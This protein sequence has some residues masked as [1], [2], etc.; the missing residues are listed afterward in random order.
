MG[1]TVTLWYPILRG[2]RVVTVPSPLDTR[3]IVDAIRDENVTV[4]LGAPTFVRPILKKAQ[5]AEL[6]SLDLVVTGAEK[7]PDDLFRTFLETFHIEIL[8]GYGLTETT[9]VTNINQPNPPVVTT[10]VDQQAGKRAGDR[11]SVVEG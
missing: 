10:A 1:F 7:L 4:L 6:R 9:P 2:C 3:K 8:Q 5:P 11:Q